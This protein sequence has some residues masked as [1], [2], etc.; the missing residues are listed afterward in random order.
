MDSTRRITP[1]D[2]NRT[3]VQAPQDPNR[4]VAADP[5]RTVIGDPNRTQMAPAPSAPLELRCLVGNRYALSTSPTVEHAVIQAR[6]SDAF[7]GRRQPLNLALVIDRS[8]SMEGEPLDYVKQ[9][10]AHV[11]DLLSPDDLLSVVTFEE[12]VDVLMPARRVV[13]KDLIKQHLMRIV[14]G[15]TT[16]LF[17]GLVAGGTQ[18]AGVPPGNY[19][20]RLL[21]LTDGEPTAG[22]KDFNSIVGQVAGLKD[23]G[24]TVT[25]LGF[26]PEYNEELLAGMARRGGGNYYYISRPD[27]LPEVFRRE[28][29]TLMTVTATNVRLALHLPRWTSVRQVYGYGPEFGPRRLEV[30]LPDLERGVTL[31]VVAEAAFDPRPAG[32]YRVFQAELLYEDAT[33]GGT[34]SLKADAVVEFVTDPSLLPAGEDPVVRQHV[35]LA[36]ASR[37]L[38]RTVMGMRTQQISPMT[39]MIELQKTQQLLVQQGRTEEAE[40]IG[41]A[42]AELRGGGMGNAEKT[43]VGTVL[44]LDQGKERSGG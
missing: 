40:E 42:V 14:A 36:Q 5:K 43:L 38:E 13:N 19:L 24:I 39:A 3:V 30:S 9:A 7:A 21:I 11:V 6:A 37:S 41:K 26:G 1:V 25:A 33:G 15:R 31:S 18:V 4:T 20:K 35:E 12:Q 28:L 27:L 44:D 23:K 32:P 2:P 22:L 34:K 17:D 29:E 16:N 8:G 10:C